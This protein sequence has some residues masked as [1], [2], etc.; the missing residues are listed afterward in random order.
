MSNEP[1]IAGPE[2]I[3]LDCEAFDRFRASHAALLEALENM[4]CPDCD[5]RLGLHADRYGCEFDRG[6]REINGLL[7]AAGPCGCNA[8]YGPGLDPKCYAEELAA[9]AAIR[10]AKGK[11]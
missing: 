2:E 1:R 5:H 8:P 6:D 3:V 7:Q 4:I 10:T 11:L 9:I